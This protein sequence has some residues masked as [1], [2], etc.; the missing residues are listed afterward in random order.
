M[1]EA[2]L[3]SLA[4]LMDHQTGPNGLFTPIGS[5]GFW[6][7]GQP[8]AQH[9]QQPLEAWASISACIS[10]ARATGSDTW[11]TEAQV[12]FNWY[13]GGNELG[14]PLYDHLTGGCRDAL[15]ADRLNEN[16]GA[17]S[18]LS[19]LCSLTE[20]ET[21]LASPAVANTSEGSI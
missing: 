14:E 15:H 13:L 10:A 1:L 17:E 11:I 9:D 20:I 12:A 18:T 5:N 19:F 16:Q 2:G 3:E 7:R 6:K 4:W 8:K 21:A